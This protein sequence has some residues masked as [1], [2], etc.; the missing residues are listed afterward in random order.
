MC[1]LR[2]YMMVAMSVSKGTPVVAVNHS[3]VGQELSLIPRPSTPHPIHVVC[4]VEGLE[5]RAVTCISV[6][7]ATGWQCDSEWPRSTNLLRGHLISPNN[8]EPSAL[9]RD[10]QA[11]K[12]HFWPSR[13]LI[14]VMNTYLVR[15]K[16]PLL[17]GWPPHGCWGTITTVCPESWS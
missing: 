4:G 11:I 10:D 8:C 17:V 3:Q 12:S 13:F 2:H 6:V 5:T 16:R 7:Q 14:T 15:C 9:G 1:I